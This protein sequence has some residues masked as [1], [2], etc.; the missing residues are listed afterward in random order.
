MSL[1]D[2]SVSSS[3][4]PN[5]TEETS[6]ECRIAKIIIQQNTISTSSG[7][8]KYVNGKS[9]LKCGVCNRTYHAMLLANKCSSCSRNPDEWNRRQNNAF[10]R[11][12]SH[13]RNS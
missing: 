5:T 13:Y 10:S 1:Q 4:E 12:Q 9:T 8:S 6:N 2:N 11:F 3:S 7:E